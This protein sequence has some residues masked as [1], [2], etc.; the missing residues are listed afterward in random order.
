MSL[1]RV[2]ISFPLK[3]GQKI[4]L[5]ATAFRHV[6]QVLRLRLNSSLVVFNGTGNEYNVTL[7]EIQKNK[8]IVS[9]DELTI[10]NKESPLSIHLGQ[11][12]AR[13]EKMDF[14]IQK[15]VELGV[16]SITPLFTE[17]C[18]VKLADDR[19]AK[20]LNHW[21]SISVSATE[22]SG[23]CYVPKILPIQDLGSW[24]RTKPSGLR[25]VLDPSVTSKLSEIAVDPDN[26]TIL[27][28]P[29]GGFSNQEINYAK[30]NHFLPVNI[31]PRVLRT[32][33]AALVAISILQAKWGDL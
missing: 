5:N 7:I 1:P 31:G 2:F 19:L 13:G 6:V 10:C 24:C 25:L 29:E 21:Q 32:E 14:T 20:R 4:E 27:V 11:G 30:Q 12:I 28:G 8:A 26:V 18:N 16:N 23:R 3:V 22:Q 9:V 17:Y 33:T 15:A